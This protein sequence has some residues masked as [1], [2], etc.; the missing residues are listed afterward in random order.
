MTD[1]IPAASTIG[2][3]ALLIAVP[4][5]AGASDS[6]AE[7]ASLAGLSAVAVEVEDLSQAAAKSGLTKS[8]LDGSIQRQLRQGGVP[9]K[10]DADAYLYVQ[11][12][13][14]EPGSGMPLAYSVRVSLMQEVTLPR[15]VTSRTPL[16]CPTWWLDTVGVAAADRFGTAVRDRVQEFVAQ[17]VRAYVAVNPK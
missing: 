10:L 1:L 15:G 2:L 14:V 5:S 11:V 9:L 13:M 16:Q 8:D 17:F 6:A 7:R 4:A 3:L 12:T